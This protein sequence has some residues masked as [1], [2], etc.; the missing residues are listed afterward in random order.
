MAEFTDMEIEGWWDIA[1]PGKWDGLVNG[2][3]KEIPITLKE[4]QTMAAAYDPELQQA[5]VTVEHEKS[6]PALAWVAELRMNGEKLQAKLKDISSTLG[7]WLKSKAYNSRSIESYSKFKPTGGPY[8]G[9]LTF[10]GAAAPAVK[11]LSPQPELFGE[12]GQPD[13]YINFTE[14]KETMD[15]KQMQTFTER[16]VGALKEWFSSPDS[17]FKTKQETVTMSEGDF[18][19][20]TQK[21]AEKDISLKAAENKLT[22]ATTQLA[23]A[24]AKIKAFKEAAAKTVKDA[25]LA[26]F[27]EG[28]KKAQAEYKLTPAEAGTYAKLAESLDSTARGVLL[29]DID[30]RPRQEAMIALFEE[31][32]KPKDKTAVTSRTAQ[33]REDAEAAWKSQKP[34][35]VDP[36]DKRVSIAAFDLMDQDEK[37]TFTEAIKRVPQA[38]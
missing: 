7:D 28:L 25:E 5:P 6:G 14:D 23:E 38:S 35:H 20:L 17:P 8:L 15:D 3:S 1:R 24:V 13:T 26:E 36:E 34:E 9:A 4:L 2:K 16:C 10:L 18:K 11:G 19:E 27:S 30:G 29:K 31:K 37:L 21:L 12:H 32:T 22:E 33:L